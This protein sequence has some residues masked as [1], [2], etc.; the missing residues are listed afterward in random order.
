MKTKIIHPLVCCLLFVLIANFS[1]S[2]ATIN[3]EILNKTV[4]I[5]VSSDRKILNSSDASVL[6]N[7]KVEKSFTGYFTGIS[8]QNWSMAGN[9]F[10]NSFYTNGNRASALFDKHGHLIYAITYVREKDMPSDVRK[11]VKSKYYDYMITLAIEVKQ[12]DRDIWIV[13]MKD[14]STY[15][16]VREEDGEME[17]EQQFKEAL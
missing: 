5:S 1:F 15:I 9:N 7:K 12:N 3:K 16:T 10:H 2:Q 13:N 17:L 4:A 6:I 8:G 11:I 14:D